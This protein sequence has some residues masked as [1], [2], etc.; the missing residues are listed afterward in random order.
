MSVR[1]MARVWELSQHRG[2]DLLMLLAIADFADDEGNAYPSVQ[3]LANKCRMK[4]RNTTAILTA[5]R[6]SGELEVRPNEGP[7]GTNRYRIVLPGHP[8]QKP[9]GVQIRAGVQKHAAT[10]AETCRKPLQNPADE[11]SV[12][13]QEPSTTKREA[14]K[15]PRFDAIFFLASRDVPDQVASDW[16]ALRRTKRSEPTK[17]AIE[18]IE[19]EAEKAGISLAD[20]LSMCCV[21]GWQSFKA[22][23][24]TRQAHKSQPSENF[25]SINY[26]EGVRSL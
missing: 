17:T 11:P 1:T 23:W 8:L 9:A 20:A 12:N 4:A 15:T 7:R 18:G 24:D 25:K 26:G 22:E 10:P 2:N 19:R 14:K 16:L 6:K 3:T 5:I 21:R 13:H